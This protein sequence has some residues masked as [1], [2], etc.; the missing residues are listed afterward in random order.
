MRKKIF[1]HTM[2]ESGVMKI[3]NKGKRNQVI[4]GNKTQFGILTWLYKSV[5]FVAQQC[6]AYGNTIAI[7]QVEV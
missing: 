5:E 6:D 2:A 7:Y 3:Q 1:I 4:H